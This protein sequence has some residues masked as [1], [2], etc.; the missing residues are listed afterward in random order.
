MQTCILKSSIVFQHRSVAQE[1]A[2]IAVQPIKDLTSNDIHNL[3]IVQPGQHQPGIGI[4]L[5]PVVIQITTDD[6]L[7][8]V[9]ESGLD[10]LQQAE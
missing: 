5:A 9:R 6:E 2:K 4:Q 8:R 1:F 3:L 10:K 7:M